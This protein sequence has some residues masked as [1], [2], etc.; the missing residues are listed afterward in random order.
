MPTFFSETS[1]YINQILLQ[2]AHLY[3]ALFIYQSGNRLSVATTACNLIWYLVKY[4]AK[5]RLGRL[6]I[7]RVP[8]PAAVNEFSHISLEPCK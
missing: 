5:A 1:Q 3:G 2:Y 6:V 4:D 7:E 8:L